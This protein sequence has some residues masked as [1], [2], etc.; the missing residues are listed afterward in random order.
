MDDVKSTALVAMKTLQGCDGTEKKNVRV[1]MA[2]KVIDRISQCKHIDGEKFV[3]LITLGYFE[4]SINVLDSVVYNEA[5]VWAKRVMDD[6]ARLCL[7]N[8]AK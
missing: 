8:Q 1:R 6:M 4:R 2:W 7:I 3:A 5:P